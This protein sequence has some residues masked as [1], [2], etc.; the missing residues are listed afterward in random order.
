MDVAGP[1]SVR[2]M[3]RIF[4]PLSHSLNY[5]AARFAGSCPGTIIKA[6]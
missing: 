1:E 5:E 2:F 6:L 3:A 4:S